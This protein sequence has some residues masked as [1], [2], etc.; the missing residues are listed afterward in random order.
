VQDWFAGYRMG[1][2]AAE[3]SGRRQWLTIPTALEDAEGSPE[4]WEPERVTRATRPRNR[5]P[6]AAPLPVPD[7]PNARFAAS[8]MASDDSSI[9]PAAYS[10]NKPQGTAGAGTRQT[11]DEPPRSGGT[12]T[13]QTGLLILPVPGPPGDQEP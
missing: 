12:T 5:A 9:V 11:A 8:L 7:V 3:Q 1:A 2:I 4:S 10:V 6:A 13:K